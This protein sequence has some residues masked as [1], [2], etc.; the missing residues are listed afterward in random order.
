MIVGIG[1]DILEIGRIENAYSRWGNRFCRK[2]LCETELS[3]LK[4]HAN[5]AR[6]LAKRFCAK[7]ALSKA[8]GT[9]MMFGVSFPQIEIRHDSKGAPIVSFSGAAQ[10]WYAKKDATH[11]NL[12]ISD[13]SQYVVAF[14]VLSRERRG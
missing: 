13:E 7:E 10:N 1:T 14:A 4:T 3:E 9:G 2:I 5:P 6:F 12:S 11:I 8:L